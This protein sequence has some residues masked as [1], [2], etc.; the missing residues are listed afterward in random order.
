LRARASRLRW[1]AMLQS[2]WLMRTIRQL[3]ESLARVVGIAK[4]GQV[5][6]AKRELDRLYSGQLGM[7]RRMV[8]RLD[9]ATAI[10]MLGVDKARLLVM[11]LEAEVEIRVAAGE[12]KAALGVAGRATELKAA[13]ERTDAA[14]LR[15]S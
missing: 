1:G 11:L 8:E 9:A 7:P 10:T 5:D 15:R 2:D 13:L 14:R 6:D 3:V 4:A 12:E